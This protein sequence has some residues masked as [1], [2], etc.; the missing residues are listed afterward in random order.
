MPHSVLLASASF[1]GTLASVRA[2]GRAGIDT[3][4]VSSN[5]L[6]AAAWSRYATRVH[7]APRE[8]YT[9]DFVNRLTE[10]G[11]ANPGLLLLPTSDQTAWAFTAYAATLRQHF[12]LYQPPL[13]TT[14]RILDK[15]LLAD[16]A[17]SAGLYP[18]PTW[19]PVSRDEVKKLSRTLPYPL[20]IKPRTHVGRVRNNKGVVV[21]T[22]SDLLRKY[23]DFCVREQVDDTLSGMDHRPVLQPFAIDGSDQIQSV[24]GFIDKS[25]ELF[26][27]RRSVKVYQRSEPVGVGICH[28]S[29]PPL[30]T[31]SDAAHR[32]CRELNYFGLFELEFVRFD[33]QWAIIDFNPRLYN[34]IGLD[35][36]RGMPLPLFAF[37]DATGQH[38][39]LRTAV[40]AAGRAEQPGPVFCDRFTLK[41]ILFAKAIFRR[42]S[43]AERRKWHQWLAQHINNSV[44]VALDEQDQ[45]P[46]LIHA[47]SEVLLGLKAL[48][49]FL[50]SKSARSLRIAPALKRAPL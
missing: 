14:R 15:K 2:F 22:A 5:R 30:A 12:L 32:L 20:L 26:V 39:A 7:S 44:D 43:S 36:G 9:S 10:I 19:D 8:T 1:G 11:A 18:L 49:R 48:P 31:L 24:T 47:F 6:S 37:L 29:L 21:E 27:T 28:E 16:A 42:A 40:V 50:L 35:I 45:L 41:A 33:G 13:D 3:H 17:L 34:Q 23:Q 25:G 38:E 46:G 4:V